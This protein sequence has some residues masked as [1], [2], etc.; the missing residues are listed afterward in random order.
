MV[1]ANFCCVQH[2]ARAAGAGTVSPPSSAVRFAQGAVATC[3]EV[4][5]THL[6]LEGISA[7]PFRINILESFGSH[8]WRPSRTLRFL[9]RCWFNKRGRNRKFGQS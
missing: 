7:S 6:A 4:M 8:T 5:P 9:S 2:A 1:L 3:Q